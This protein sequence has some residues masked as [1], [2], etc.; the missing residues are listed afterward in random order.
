MAQGGNAGGNKCQKPSMEEEDND[1]DVVAAEVSIYP[2]SL[3]G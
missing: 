1:A 2:T 3:L